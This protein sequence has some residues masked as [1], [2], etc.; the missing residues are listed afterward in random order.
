MQLSRLIERITRSVGGSGPE[1]VGGRPPPV[2]RS[3]AASSLPPPLR[4]IP[5]VPGI[6][7]G[8]PGRPARQARPPLLPPSPHCRF[9]RDVP[10]LHRPR[11]HEQKNILSLERIH[12]TRETNRNFDTCNSCKRMVPSHLHELHKSKLSFVSRIE[13]IRSKLSNTSAHLSGVAVSLAAAPPGF[14]SPVRRQLPTPVRYVPLPPPRLPAAVSTAAPPCRSSVLHLCC[15]HC[16][17]S[18]VSPSACR[19][20]TWA[21]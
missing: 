15:L 11:I 14:V 6:W 12:S 2:R 8:A 9:H 3:A 10:P 17:D 18:I 19:H 21:N 16:P 13:T 4:S 7:S 20:T 5:T 1:R